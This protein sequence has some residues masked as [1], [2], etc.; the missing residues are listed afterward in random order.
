[1]HKDERVRLFLSWIARI[2]STFTSGVQPFSRARALS[3]SLSLP[4]CAISAPVF[5]PVSFWSI[6][7]LSARNTRPNDD[8]RHRSSIGNAHV[9]HTQKGFCR[10]AA[11]VAQL[12]N[13]EGN[14]AE[15]PSPL[16]VC[17]T[18]KREEKKK[19]GKKQ[20]RKSVR[21]SRSNLVRFILF[22][23]PCRNST[24]H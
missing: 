13:I 1:M 24:W 20:C 5:D 2:C 15:N 7:V 4:V 11:H 12:M 3:L 17:T 22:C 6:L 16:L 23:S 8:L 9:T 18:E 21:N 19:T 10:G 14:G